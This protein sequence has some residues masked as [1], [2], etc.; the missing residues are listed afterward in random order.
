MLGAD[1]GRYPCQI[2]LLRHA[3]VKA[4]VA[5]LWPSMQA[6]RHNALARGG[7]RGLL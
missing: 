1:P 7:M 4:S 5:R 3:D 2:N 6:L